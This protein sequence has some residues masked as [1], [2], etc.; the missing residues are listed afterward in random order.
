MDR[1]QLILGMGGVVALGAC[2]SADGKSRPS[3][4]RADLYQCE[5]CEG[6]FERQP[7]ASSARIAPPGEPGEPLVL[8]GTVIALDGRPAAGVTIYAYHTNSA[9]FYANGTPETEWSRRHGRLRGWAKTGADGR[10]RFETIKPA[11]YPDRS[12][13]AH[14]HLTVLEPG[15]RPY[16]IDDIVFDDDA[17]VDAAYRRR[18]ENRGGDGIVRLDREADGRL[19]AV[20]D[21][22]L[23]RHPA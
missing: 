2:R 15:R 14:V 6:V 12:L 5:G 19:L 22:L 3:A 11:P 10:Y 21:I 9:G 1:R 23:E 8:A 20:R 7:T 17:L 13:P 4:A 16:W 18:M